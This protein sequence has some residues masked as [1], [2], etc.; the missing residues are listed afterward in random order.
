MPCTTVSS[1]VALYFVG[2]GVEALEKTE[3]VLYDLIFMDIQMPRM[4]GYAATKALIVRYGEPRNKPKIVGMSAHAMDEHR[5]R[6]FEA[7]MNDYI[8]KPVDFAQFV[9]VIHGI[10]NYWFGIAA[11]P[12]RQ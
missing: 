10:G 4:D 12:G 2:H 5:S 9:N 11:L 1:D 7:G 3:D 8:T 6:G